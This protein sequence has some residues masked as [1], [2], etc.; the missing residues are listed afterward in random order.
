MIAISAVTYKGRA[1]KE[2]YDQLMS[3]LDEVFFTEDNPETRRDFLRL[4]PKLYKPEYDPC[5]NNIV[6]KEGDSIKAAVGLFYDT[7]MAG[8][9]KLR[10]GGIGNVAVGLDSR[11]KGYMIE[12]MNMAV[13]DMIESGA[14]F[15]LLG[16][17]RQR[18][19]Y[20]GFEPGGSRYDF[21]LNTS[22]I[23]HCFGKDAKSGLEIKKLTADDTELLKQIDEMYKSEPYYVVHEP[24]KMFDILCSWR[25][26]PYAALKDGELKGLL[27]L[28][29]EGGLAVF[30]AKDAQ[31]IDSLIL[32]AFELTEARS[33]E[34][35][36]AP[37]DKPAIKRLLEIAEGCAIRRSN[38]YTVLNY[39]KMVKALMQA[40]SEKVRLANGSLTLS[41]KGYAGDEKFKIR[42][43]GGDISVIESKGKADFE[44]DHGQAMRFL[45]SH[46]SAERE[47][48]TTAAAQWFPLPLN[49]VSFD[50]V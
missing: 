30:K 31:S 5:S 10:C 37:Y 34:I 36:V 24:E 4:L 21:S 33:I 28:N 41:V 7:V 6:I 46:L 11:S 42:V 40:K 43:N 12:C 22:N 20:F 8:G 16:G 23:R 44:L 35:S 32:A 15:G 47:G 2:D 25:S 38:C 49:T 18:Y 1:P 13:E 29:F 3:F 48:F 9:E 26:V 27:I 45:F 39:K 14:D 17:Q 19:A 50:S